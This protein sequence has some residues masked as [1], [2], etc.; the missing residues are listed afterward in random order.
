MST[1]KSEINFEAKQSGMPPHPCFIVATLTNPKIFGAGTPQGDLVVH[2]KPE[3]SEQKAKEIA[4]LLEQSVRGVTY[5][6]F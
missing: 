3:V 4:S 5:S 6:T 2:L 1:L